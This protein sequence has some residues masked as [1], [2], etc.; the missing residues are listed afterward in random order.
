[1]FIGSDHAGFWAKQKTCDYIRSLE[2]QIEDLGTDSEKPVDYPDYAIKVAQRVRETPGACGIV[3]CGT[4]IGVSITA[5]KVPGIRAALCTSPYH[6]EMARR[7]N[8]ANVLALGARISTFEE[9]KKMIDVWFSTPFDGGRH[10][11]RVEKIHLL[12]GC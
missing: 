10:Q 2:Y 4:G 6:V 5:N 9:I 3:F 8:D 11:R 1:M 12:T 7:H